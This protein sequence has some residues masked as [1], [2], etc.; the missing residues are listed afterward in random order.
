M[1]V[2]ANSS[3]AAHM[4]VSTVWSFDGFYTVIT[5]FSI[6]SPYFMLVALLYFIGYIN[7]A[8]RG[9]ISLTTYGIKAIVT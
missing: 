1:L 9:E 2:C 6:I 4:L 7:Y 8:Q 5:S 3:F